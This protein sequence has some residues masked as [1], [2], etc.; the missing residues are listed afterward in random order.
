MLIRF[1]PVDAFPKSDIVCVRVC[2]CVQMFHLMPTPQSSFYVLNDIFRLNYAWSHLYERLSMSLDWSSL[3]E[4]MKS[5]YYDFIM[6]FF[7][8]L[9]W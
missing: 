6:F 2:V 8:I 3:G 1:V 7:L 5:G 9:F 4:Q